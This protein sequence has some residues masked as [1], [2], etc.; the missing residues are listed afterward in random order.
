MLRSPTQRE[1][2]PNQPDS[3]W[4]QP[5]IR[6]LPSSWTPAHCFRRLS[7]L[8]GCVWLD[9]SLQYEGL[10]RYSYL[11]AS[12]I[13]TLRLD[14]R[15]DMPLAVVQ[16]T[17]EDFYC[18]ALPNVP[19]MQ[20]GWMG[21]L[22]YELGGCYESIASAK[23]NDF[24]LPLAMLGLYDVVLSWDHQTGEGFIVSQGWPYRDPST[25][26]QN[27][28]RR[29]RQF[30]SILEVED[31]SL[32]GQSAAQRQCRAY[33]LSASQLAPAHATRW[34]KDWT[35]NFSPQQY[36][37]AVERCVQ[38]VHAGDIFQVNLSQ[39]LL[40]P[41]TC[42]PEEL[43]LHLRRISPAPFAGY[44]D[45]GR[46]QVISS[47]P[48]RLLSIR[49]GDIEARPIKG[50]RP[51]LS[52]PVADAGIAQL[53][54]QSPKD[55]S[56]NV[57]IVDLLRN[58]ISRIAQPDSIQVTALAELER[59]PHVWHLVS[60][61]RAKL[62]SGHQIPEI[63]ESIFPGG[64]ITGAPKIRAMQVIAE[65]EPTVRGPYCG[66]LGYFSAAGDIDLNILIRTVTACDGWWQVSVGGGIVADSKPE[67]EE[68]ET[69]HKA[70]GIL[71]AIDSLPFGRRVP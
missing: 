43:A 15:T 27:A 22:G 12:P 33:R 66:S 52:D 41:A 47:S 54:L 9:S 70:R 63:I 1:T 55:R 6:R 49:S 20:G 21:W 10:S 2:Q 50:T 5:L 68:Q 18:P 23:V 37:Q 71:T 26:Q 32:P 30:L 45:F 40:R 4:V 42:D 38:Y 31:L 69:W 57:M 62:A 13:R 34:S 61:I 25:R 36:R 3:D 19:P 53:L 8:E 58:D 46:I 48:E 51:R 14:N 11:A 24:H 64:S 60:V 17:I 56:E 59:Y 29:L 39:R 35:S 65:I 16:R 28:Y 7:R 44:A 67:W